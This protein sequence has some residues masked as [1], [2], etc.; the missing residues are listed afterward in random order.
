MIVKMKRIL[1]FLLIAF[2][3]ISSNAQNLQ[4]VVYLKNGSM[5]R[6]VVLEQIPNESIKIQ[7]ADGSIF[8]YKMDEVE[9]ITKEA[10]SNSNLKTQ[11]DDKISLSY[12]HRGYRGFVSIGTGITADEASEY[13]TYSVSTTHGVQVASPFFIGGGLGFDFYGDVVLMPIFSE[14]RFDFVKAK[15]SPFLGVRAGY[16][17]GDNEGLYASLQGGVRL[18]YVSLSLAYSLQGYTYYYGYNNESWGPGTA[19]S[20]H[21]R[22]TFDW[23]SR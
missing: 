18:K 21:F 1:L 17:I 14:L 15:V 2:C 6:G 13:Y 4:E 11:S 22:I 8:V 9:K 12:P 19:Q 5:I 3:A 10:T 7:T 20:L 16:S 23:G